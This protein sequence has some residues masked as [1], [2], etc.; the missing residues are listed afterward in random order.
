VDNRREV[1]VLDTHGTI[2]R[3]PPDGGEEVRVLRWIRPALLA[4]LAVAAVAVAMTVGVP[5]IEDV[6]AAVGAAGWAGPVLYAGLYAALSLTPTPATV[7]SIG[8]GVLFGLAVG[9][10]VVLAGALVG[11]VAG[12][13]L[14]RLLGRSTVAGLGGDRLARLDALL[15]RRGLLAMV[16][17]RLVPTVPFAMLNAACGLTGVRARDY[18]LGTAVGIVPAAT[19]LVAVGAYGADPVS[20]P[21]LLSA[22]GLAVLLIGGAVLARRSHAR[23]WTRSR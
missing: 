20:V 7:L 16:A 19:A 11:A 10:P 5:P 12:F 1:T 21:F 6:R 15:Q 3:E 13:A 14:A 2:V 23:L 9:V 8:G 22:G 4:V 18:V 17:V